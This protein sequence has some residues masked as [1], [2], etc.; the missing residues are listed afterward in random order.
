MLLFAEPGSTWALHVLAGQARARHRDAW[1]AAARGDTILL[2]AGEGERRRLPL[3]GGGELLV[4]R[5][6]PAG[7]A[8]D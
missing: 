8:V 3:E 4:V 5:V 2:E 7:V 6:T 1:I